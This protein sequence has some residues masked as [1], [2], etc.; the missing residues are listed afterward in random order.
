MTV[1]ADKRDFGSTVEPRLGGMSS[2]LGNNDTWMWLLL[3]P[4]LT[5][6]DSKKP[7]RSCTS[8]A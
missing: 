5:L 3:W 7:A 2:C 8:F 4:V 6:L 1:T